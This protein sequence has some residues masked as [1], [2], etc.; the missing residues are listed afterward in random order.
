MSAF[1]FSTDLD[2]VARGAGALSQ[3]VVAAAINAAQFNGFE[4]INTIK[5]NVNRLEGMQLIT[6]Q[7]HEQLNEL[8]DALQSNRDV[9]RL[10]DGIQQTPD[11]SPLAIALASITAASQSSQD[12]GRQAVAL[13][14]AVVGAL[15][16]FGSSDTLATSADGAPSGKALACVLAAVGAAAATATD[17]LV[18]AR[19]T[20]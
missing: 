7:E 1:M 20:A 5:Y 15:V 13:S 4:V 2:A 12:P 6:A 18:H 19:A 9:S 3:R 17:A 14:S 8:A 11:A 10:T 16:M